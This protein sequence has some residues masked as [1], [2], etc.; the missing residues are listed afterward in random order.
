MALG[1]AMAPNAGVRIW[2]HNQLRG[3]IRKLTQIVRK[4]FQM[5]MSGKVVHDSL[6]SDVLSWAME[7]IKEQFDFVVG[8]VA[9]AL[10]SSFV[11]RVDQ[12]S[13]AAVNSTV[14]S[15]G[16]ET[17]PQG[18]SQRV[19]TVLDA[20]IAA[21]ASLI[22]N[23]AD[24]MYHR[25]SMAVSNSLTSE[26]PEHQGMRGIYRHLTEVEGIEDGRARFIA[27]DQTSKVYTTINSERMKGA[28]L[29]K[30]KW[31]H[32]AAG[33]TFRQCHV[34]HD[35]EVFL[36]EGGPDELYY[37]DGSDANAGLKKGDRGKPGWAP[38]CH[39]QMQ[40]VLDL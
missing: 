13:K 39:C 38:F 23:L 4:N 19:S 5:A 25:I 28:G 40:A 17:P 18:T 1:T 9:S 32:T 6:F 12:T 34:D 7:R 20:Q 27:E 3:Y 26:D 31:V 8:T 33:K 30:F 14:M 11:S 35:G 22:K 10:A 2:Y 29:K 21:N 24:D 16:S 15:F 37:E 36:L